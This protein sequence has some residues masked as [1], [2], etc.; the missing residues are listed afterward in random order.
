MAA[1]PTIYSIKNESGLGAMRAF[2][3]GDTERL[4][5]PHPASPLLH[6]PPPAG[7]YCGDV[8]TFQSLLQT[9]GFHLS[10]VSRSFFLSQRFC[11]GS[12]SETETRVCLQALGLTVLNR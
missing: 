11:H 3:T 2:I 10:L 7:L 1:G 8:E 4:A 12:V 6:P 9:D 5:L